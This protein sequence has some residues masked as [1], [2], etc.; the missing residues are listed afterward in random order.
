VVSDLLDSF[1]AAITT[2]IDVFDP[3]FEPAQLVHIDDGFELAIAREG[4]EVAADAF[5]EGEVELLGFGRSLA[6][7]RYGR[8]SGYRIQPLKTTLQV[9][10]ESV[11]ALDL[12]CSTGKLHDFQI[13]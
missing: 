11:G 10:V 4:R 2:V 6:N 5:C 3:S 1:E 12:H 9:N 8:R 13:L 7:R